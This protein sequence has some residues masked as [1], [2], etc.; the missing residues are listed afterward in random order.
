MAY[1]KRETE[2]SGPKRGRGAYQGRKVDAKKESNKV[3][4]QRSVVTT[5]EAFR[6]LENE[7]HW[8][9]LNI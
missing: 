8:V 3:R 4:R 1:H 2:H 5:Q 6:D 9:F 7:E